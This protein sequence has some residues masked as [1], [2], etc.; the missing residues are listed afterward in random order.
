MR[1]TLSHR[2]CRSCTLWV[3]SW[4]W[5][6]CLGPRLCGSLLGLV[7]PRMLSLFLVFLDL[8]NALFELARS[9]ERSLNRHGKCLLSGA[10]T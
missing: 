5:I 7:G 10:L 6:V 1:F 4:W 2:R 3:D 8:F 9:T